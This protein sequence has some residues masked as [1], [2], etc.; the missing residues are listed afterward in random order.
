MFQP[1]TA[2]DS[3][4][5]A[6]CTPYGCA[7]PSSPE[8]ADVTN[9]MT[10]DST[11]ISARTRTQ[12]RPRPLATDFVDAPHQVSRHQ[13]PRGGERL[14]LHAGHDDDLA[15]GGVGET[16]PHHVFDLEPQERRGAGHLDARALVE[17]G[18]HE[19]GAQ[20]VHADA[21][22]AEPVGQALGERDH[23]RLGRRVGRPA[24]G[25][26]PGDAGDVDDGARVRGQHR[27]QRGVR[28]LHD[29]GD[30]DVQ[31]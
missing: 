5:A 26:Q 20:R 2:S 8:H 11:A 30:V 28:Q 7:P 6:A 23:P 18:V 17:L 12:V 16:V 1:S 21:R 4:T 31:L 10:A 19:A 14:V 24:P 3:P 27:R 22:A 13:P 29:R 15:L 25:Q 9:S